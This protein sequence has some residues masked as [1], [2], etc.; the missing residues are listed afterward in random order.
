MNDRN[1][2][3]QNTDFIGSVIDLSDVKI[4]GNKLVINL[5]PEQLE[6][7]TCSIFSN[8]VKLSTLKPKEKPKDEFKIGNRLVMKYLLF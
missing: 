4:K 2:T 6:I 5:S 8:K 1:T 3:L 7:L